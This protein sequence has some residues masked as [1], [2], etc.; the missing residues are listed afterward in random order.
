MKAPDT[1]D[2][3]VWSPDGKTIA[4]AVFSFSEGLKAEVVAIP[5]EGGEPKP[6]SAQTWGGMDEI[7]WLP[8]GSGLVLTASDDPFSPSQLWEVSYPQGIARRI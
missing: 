1:F 3:P 2:D 8:D 7:S 4:V 5:L 6:I